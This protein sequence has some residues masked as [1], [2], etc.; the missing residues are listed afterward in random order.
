MHIG[1][2]LAGALETAHRR[3]ILHRDVK[4]GNILLTEYG[5]PQLTDFGI[6]RIAGGFETA[7]GAITGSPAFTAPEVL[8]GQPPDPSCRPVQP[9]RRPCSASSPG[10]RCSSASAASRWSRSSCGSPVNRCPTSPTPGSPRGS[11]RGDRTSDVT[12]SRISTGHRRRVRR[13]AA[14]RAASPRP[15]GRRDSRSRS[16]PSAPVSGTRTGAPRRL[17]TGTSAALRLLRA[18]I[19]PPAPA[20]RFRPPSTSRALVV[21]DRLIQ[22]LR[23][24]AAPTAHRDP[25]AHRVRQEHPRRPV[26]RRSDR[27]RRGRSRGSRSTTTTT[28]SSGSSRT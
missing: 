22:A 8:Q 15:A 17:T 23:A 4:P 24:G 9:R 16:T 3:G 19:S 26:G 7:A 1:V 20:T 18:T 2:K 10:T 6:A 13:D 14:G 12:R 21:R 27:R 11:H 5:E 28:T 25:R